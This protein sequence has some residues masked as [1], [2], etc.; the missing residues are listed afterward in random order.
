MNKIQ[1]KQQR[2]RGNPGRARARYDVMTVA[3]TLEASTA[4][5]TSCIPAP[6]STPG[7]L[8]GPD[9]GRVGAL[10]TMSALHGDA[11]TDP[12]CRR[13][14]QCRRARDGPAGELLPA[15]THGPGRSG[16]PPP[17]S[18]WDLARGCETCRTRKAQ[19]DQPE[20][21]GRRARELCPG[22]QHLPPSPDGWTK[23]ESG[24]GTD[25]IH[26]M[27]GHCRWPSRWTSWENQLPLRRPLTLSRPL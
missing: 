18:A 25:V 5:Q 20:P 15:R 11:H 8:R 4:P 26:D 1:K 22:G 3:G 16:Q 10:T 14:R 2:E 9:K 24:V 6:Q 12:A 21:A 23:G 7:N 17:A 27:Q 13:D 19:G